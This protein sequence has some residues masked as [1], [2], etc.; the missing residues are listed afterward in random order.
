MRGGA[1]GESHLLF[2][3]MIQKALMECCMIDQLWKRN[4]IM[5]SIEF[6]LLVGSEF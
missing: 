4:W 5:T 6:G 3:A 2:L 1:S